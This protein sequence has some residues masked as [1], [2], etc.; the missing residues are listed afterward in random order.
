M[1]NRSE[2]GEWIIEED[3]CTI[4]IIY[5]FMMLTIKLFSEFPLVF[6]TTAFPNLDTSFQSYGYRGSHDGH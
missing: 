4:I 2:N 6:Q 1:E 5:D 3:I